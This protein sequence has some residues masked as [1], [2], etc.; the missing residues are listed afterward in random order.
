MSID[1]QN[2]DISHFIVVGDRVLI[3]PKTDDGKTKTGLFLPPGVKE[4]EKI[5]SGYIVKAGPGYAIP[6]VDIEEDWKTKKNDAKYIPL[7]AKQGDLAVYLQ[8]ATFEIEFNNE[9]YV[10]VPHTA[11]LLLIRDEGLFE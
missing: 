3:K 2:Q 4:K 9:K 5:Q 1:L 8:K 10:I 6:S 7:Q 11:I